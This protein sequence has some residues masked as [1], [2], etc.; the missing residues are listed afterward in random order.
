MGPRSLAA[1]PVLL[2][3]ILTELKASLWKIHRDKPVNCAVEVP[4]G[5]SYPAEQGDLYE[6][7]G[8]LLDNAWKWC[9]SEILVTVQ[10]GDGLTVVVADD[11]PGIPVN[12]EAFA[13]APCSVQLKPLSVLR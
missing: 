9:R 8:N 11:G 13:I 4:D 1:R 2:A 12:S 6:I 5:S 3:P 10:T 7:L